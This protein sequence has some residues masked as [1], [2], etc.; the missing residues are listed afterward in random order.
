ML[1]LDLTSLVWIDSLN[2][3]LFGLNYY[4]RTRI[5]L[6]FVIGQ[7]VLWVHNCILL[8]WLRFHNNWNYVLVLEIQRHIWCFLLIVCNLNN[9]IL[10]LICFRNYIIYWNV[11]YRLLDY[12]RFCFFR[13]FIYLLY[14]LLRNLVNLLLR[15]LYYRYDWICKFF[16]MLVYVIYIDISRGLYLNF[17]TVSAMHQSL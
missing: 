6:R 9:W 14:L 16:K 1:Y 4:W 13:W 15:L 10:N 3:I 7:I 11:V 12:H 17:S 8:D 2:Q 5:H